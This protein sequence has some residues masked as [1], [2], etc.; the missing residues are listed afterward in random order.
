V[1]GFKTHPCTIVGPDGIVR[2]KPQAQFAGAELIVIKGANV[3][4]HP[5]DE[6]RRE[7]PNGTEEAFTVINPVFYDAHFGP[8][9]Q[10]KVRR[11]GMFP[12]HAGGNYNVSVTGSNARVN[13]GSHDQSTNVVVGDIFGDICDALKS[14]IKDEEQLDSLLLATAEMRH[15][16]GNREG[17][18]PAY[19]KFISLAAEHMTVIAPFLPALAGMIG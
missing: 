19:Q 12:A 18:L 1:L 6:I 3:V 5:G 13:I 8:H 17:F 9:F 16:Q 2:S 15:E 14:A 11:K 10:I 7:L 4:V